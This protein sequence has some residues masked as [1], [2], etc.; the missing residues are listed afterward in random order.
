M[1]GGPC[2]CFSTRPESRGLRTGQG[3]ISLQASRKLSVAVGLDG[4]EQAAA[5]G[6]AVHQH[7]ARSADAMLAADVGAGQAELFA[8][9]IDQRGCALPRWPA[10]AD[11]SQ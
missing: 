5:D 1:P 9:E 10:V 6:L 11:R 8:Q 7:R 2:L 3:A 4:Q